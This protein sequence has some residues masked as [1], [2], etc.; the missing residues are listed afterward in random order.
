MQIVYQKSDG[1]VMYAGSDLTSAEIANLGE[2][3]CDQRVSTLLASVATVTNLPDDWLP[4]CYTYD[5][6]TQEFT[7][8]PGKEYLLV[9]GTTTASGYPPAQPTNLAVAITNEITGAYNSFA[10]IVGTFSWDDMG[11]SIAYYD[12]E[13]R[14]N[15]VPQWT[16]VPS[17]S[18]P[19]SII[20]GLAVA[21]YYFRVRA[22]TL[23]GVPGS[24]SEFGPV[25]VDSIGDSAIEKI[26]GL[27]IWGQGNNFEFTG[28]NPRFHWNASTGI[29]DPALTEVGTQ[30]DWHIG[31]KIQIQNLDGTLRREVYQQDT[32]FVYSFEDNKFDGNGIPARS[33]KV[34]VWDQYMSGYF[35][36]APASITV[37]NPQCSALQIVSSLTFS[38]GFALTLSLPGDV[39]FAG[40]RLWA[41]GLGT[42]DFSPS[43]NIG[44]NCEPGQYTV[45]V[46]PYDS[47]GKDSL[48]AQQIVVTVLGEI[49]ASDITNWAEDVTKFFKVPVTQAEIFTAND[50]GAG[51]ISWN[52]H[53]VYFNGVK[54][55]IT[56]SNTSDPYVYWDSEDPTSYKT[57]SDIN[58]F[59]AMTSSATLWQMIY[60]INGVPEP[61]WSGVPNMVIGMGWLGKAVVLNENIGDTIESLGFEYVPGVKASG[62]H[63]D[64]TG[65]LI[66]QA[67]KIVDE[68]GEIVFQAGDQILNGADGV[69]AYVHVAYATSADGSTGFSFT[70][71]SYM[72][73]YTDT[74]QNPSSDPT[75]YNWVRI[76]GAS[77]SNG[78]PAYVHVAYADNADGTLNFNSESGAYIGIYTDETA[79]DSSDPAD[80]TWNQIKGTDGTSGTDGTNGTS[81]F[82]YYLEADADL[83]TIS[84]PSVN[85]LAFSAESG[86]TWRFNGTSWDIISI[87]P[88]K[89][90][91]SDVAIGSGGLVLSNGA[92]ITNVGS[93]GTTVLDSE[94]LYFADTNGNVYNYI[95]RTASGQ[96]TSG[97]WV[98]LSPPFKSIPKVNLIPRR[99][100]SYSKDYPDSDQFFRLFVSELAS[101]G[102]RINAQLVATT[103]LGNSQSGTTELTAGN[104]TVMTTPLNTT[105][106][107]VN[108][109]IGGW[110]SSSVNFVSRLANKYAYS[111]T[112]KGYT[113]NRLIRI[114]YKLA[115]DPTYTTWAYFSDIPGGDVKYYSHILNYVKS[116]LP[117]G[118]YNVRV[119]LV[120]I[121]QS[122]VLAALGATYPYKSFSGSVGPLYSETPG[123]ESFFYVGELG[124]LKWYFQGSLLY[125]GSNQ[126]YNEGI[127]Y[128]GYF[129]K[130]G[131]LRRT[132]MYLGEPSGDYYEVTKIPIG[133]LVPYTS[134]EMLP[135]FAHA[136]STIFSEMNTGSYLI[137]SDNGDVDFIAY[138]GG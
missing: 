118:Q 133:N 11:I 70:T 138:D 43:T 5:E 114:E 120:S 12:V 38:K 129:F 10:V 58:A 66:L 83:Y 44:L 111:C 92:R 32:D 59:S 26:T 85:E 116:D 84:N 107:S 121:S 7:V 69:S 105:E 50:P 73:T 100:L 76:L 82:T 6:V 25:T 17:T 80:Y 136:L 1:L 41:T 2:G 48:T 101:D 9:A 113:P 104:S 13:Y 91:E 49:Q 47:F 89:A 14:K 72:G 115:S 21:T 130:P 29:Y 127:D 75:S 126:A 94:N 65:E 117:A 119:T 122:T 99:S 16:A 61:A 55:N 56:S 81:T 27:E 8:V 30:T 97:D 109:S 19:Y 102:F 103:G 106:I 95:G 63:M 51:S 20:R 88:Q 54:Y 40:I 124:D 53:Q 28:L 39:D 52:A 128:G 86:K 74:N 35:S 31:Y 78:T 67:F 45:N 87:L 22:V 34:L 135:T 4:D 108:I 15:A 42:Y 37:N 125:S 60:N 3:W 93:N 132:E 134:A 57:T 23:E 64:K 33:F 62:W 123:S 71:G 98:P 79:A 77:G 46:A 112:A 24:W 36:T 131:N 110:Y 68:N 137:L 18:E 90:L 96:A